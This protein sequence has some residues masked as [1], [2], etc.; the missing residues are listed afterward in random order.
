MTDGQLRFNK[1]TT[2]AETTLG[3]PSEVKVQESFRTQRSC[4]NAPRVIR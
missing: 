3:Y 4:E 2:A 1:L